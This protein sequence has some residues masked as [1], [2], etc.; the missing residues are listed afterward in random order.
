MR[1]LI[2]SLVVSGLI[3]S[4][5]EAQQSPATDG[6]GYLEVTLSSTLLN[7]YSR[8]NLDTW[9]AEQTGTPGRKVDQ[10]SPAFFALEG[11]RFYPLTPGKSWLTLGAGIIFPADH[12]LWGTSIFFGGSRQLVVQPSIISMNMTS[13]FTVE[14]MEGLTAEFGGGLLIGWVTGEYAGTDFDYD[15]TFGPGIGFALTGGANYMFS[16]KF[17]LSVKSG[18]R[19]LKTDLVIRNPD[20]PTGYFQIRLDNDDEVKPNLG[21]FYLTIGV[22]LRPMLIM[23]GRR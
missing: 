8:G 13:V 21:G 9:W 20:S 18:L 12:A 14:Q 23:G 2:V 15:V 4:V 22:T 3:P 10:G 17:G 19:F 7:S 11:R 16:D 6:K 5:A 1:L